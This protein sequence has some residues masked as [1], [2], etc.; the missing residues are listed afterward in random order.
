[1]EHRYLQVSAMLNHIRKNLTEV[2]NFKLTKIHSNSKTQIKIDFSRL[3]R[4]SELGRSRRRGPST[5]F[6][7]P[8]MSAFASPEESYAG[9]F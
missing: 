1:M 2:G 9:R 3:S 7:G 5:T 6:L 8:K 4:V